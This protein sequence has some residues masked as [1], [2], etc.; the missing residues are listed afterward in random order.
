MDGV[1]SCFQGPV[2]TGQVGTLTLLAESAFI[3]RLPSSYSS[4]I[5]AIFESHWFIWTALLGVAGAC[6][7]RG[8]RDGHR[9]LMQVGAVVGGITIFW[10]LLAW[11]VITP[12]E[13]LI[14]ANQ[15][16]VRAA[17]HDDVA[18]IVHFLSPQAVV[19]TW[20]RSRVAAEVQIRLNAARISGNFIRMLKVRLH[21][22]RA[23]VRLVVWTQTRDWGPFITAWQL[24]WQD[25]ARP[26]DWRIVRVSLLSVNSHPLSPGESI[27]MVPW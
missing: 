17:A 22:K 6:I 24:L 15:A 1:W 7:W 18:G 8:L 2:K 11:L 4:S 14:T 9:R 25:H 26:G 21:G 10:I 16:V 3:L 5:A 19:G 13:R 27:P 20:P 12:R 23:R